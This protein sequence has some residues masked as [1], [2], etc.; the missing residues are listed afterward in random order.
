MF[1]HLVESIAEV[2]YDRDMSNQG[3]LEWVLWEMLDPAVQEDFLKV[4]EEIVELIEDE[5]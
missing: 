2:I 4:A 3:Y 5:I 1:E